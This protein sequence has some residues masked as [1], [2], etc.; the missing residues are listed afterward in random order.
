MNFTLPLPQVNPADLDAMAE[1]DHRK[2]FVGNS[3]YPIIQAT[4]GDYAGRVTGMLLDESVTNYKDLISNQV[5]FNS[6]CKEAYA[7][8]LQSMQPAPQQQM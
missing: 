2:E 8:L 4:I 5:Y 6:K 7:L 3:I 1:A